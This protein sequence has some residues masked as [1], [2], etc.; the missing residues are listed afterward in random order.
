MDAMSEAMIKELHEKERIS[1][2]FKVRPYGEVKETLD[3]LAAET[4]KR[5]AAGLVK[6]FESRGYRH[7]L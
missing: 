5:S 2:Q 3:K 6:L 4:A 7:G 1:R